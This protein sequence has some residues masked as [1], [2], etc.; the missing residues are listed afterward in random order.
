[1][2]SEP[3]REKR[4]TKTYTEAEAESGLI[5]LAVC[6]GGSEAGLRNGATTEAV[7]R[8]AAQ[9]IEVN[10][11]TLKSWKRRYP[12]RFESIRQE[13]LPRIRARMAEQSENAALYM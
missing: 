6:G 8:L 10:P 7:K 1:M 4:V 5:E 2:A 3:A 11:N 12:E 13:V 9:G